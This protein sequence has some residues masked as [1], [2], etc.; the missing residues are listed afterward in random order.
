M[1]L[2]A[3]KKAGNGIIV[4][5]VYSCQTHKPTTDIIGPYTKYGTTNKLYVTFD[6]DVKTTITFTDDY[7]VQRN[8]YIEIV[9]DYN[10]E[11]N[12]TCTSV[13]EMNKSS[14]RVI[15]MRVVF[16]LE[17]PMISPS[18]E[19]EHKLQIV[20]N[21]Y[22]YMWRFYQDDYTVPSII[23]PTIYANVNRYVSGVPYA[24]VVNVSAIV[25]NAV[26][27]F[28]NADYI[29][30]IYDESNVFDNDDV[31][32][33]YI[34]N[35]LNEYEDVGIR[36]SISALPNKY[37]ENVRLDVYAR[38]ASGVISDVVSP[39]NA[40]LRVDT[41]SDES[42]RCSSLR[43]Q[44]PNYDAGCDY[45]YDAQQSLLCNEELQMIGGLYQYPPHIN[46]KVYK[47]VGPDY[48]HIS[49]GSYCGFRWVTFIREAKPSNILHI[50]LCDAVGFDNIIEDGF[51][52]YVCVD[53]IWLDGNRNYDDD[54]VLLID[55]SDATHKSLYI[56]WHNSR[57][58][59][60]I[61]I[62]DYEKKFS[63]IKIE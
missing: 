59:V 10:V 16:P 23:L 18:N 27:K 52:L 44:Y 55:K 21:E 4:D 22:A 36:M 49:G 50:T 25:H 45:K 2:Y 60:R 26:C 9:S 8:G 48:S 34:P 29:A 47:P 46:Y 20:H 1:N 7:D 32:A 6:N 33:K 3:A 42:M 17:A 63:G 61:G 15:T 53:S 40:K 5:N 12:G 11:M 51:A 39:T 43:G 38:S 30:W 35:V 13:S 57:I 19:V 56:G 37:C 24:N 41:I 62:N 31:R 28:Y 14:E 54:G 58:I